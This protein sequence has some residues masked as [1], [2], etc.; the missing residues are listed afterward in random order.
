MN[1]QQELKTLLHYD[2]DTGI[3]TWKKTVS[4]K[5]I[6]GA[7]AGTTNTRGYIT[8]TYRGKKLKAHALAW[9]YVYGVHPTRKLDHINRI[10]T[11]NRIANLRE[12]SDRE[13]SLNNSLRR[14]STTG[15]PG[16]SFD[17]QR[18]RWRAHITVHGKHLALGRFKH[19]AD[20]EFARQQAEIKYGF[21]QWKG[22]ADETEPQPPSV[23]QQNNDT[24]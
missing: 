22:P 1:T 13:N 6:G 24:P 3:F 19:R 8:I 23:A 11:D 15:M 20:A 17:R 21:L 7:E 5:A 4:S 9:L 18:N 16:I 2:P 14:D 12:V 10:R